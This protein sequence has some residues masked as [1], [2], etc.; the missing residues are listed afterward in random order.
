M[1]LP[2]EFELSDGITTFRVRFDY[3]KGEREWFDAKEG[4]GSPGYGPEA[5]ITEVNFG[6]GWMSP[7]VFPQL[8]LEACEVEILDKL[9][10]IEEEF[11]DLRP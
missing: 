1:K 4:V 11:N 9:A 10:K 8:D 2:T 6:G 3:D 5:N 7:E